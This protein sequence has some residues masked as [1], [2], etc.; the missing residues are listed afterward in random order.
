MADRLQSQRLLYHTRLAQLGYR[1]RVLWKS[2]TI[3][4]RG[5]NGG[6]VQE[7]NGGRIHNEVSRKPLK[8]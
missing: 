7:E 1:T 4:G 2:L 3:T 8:L 5:A 6:E